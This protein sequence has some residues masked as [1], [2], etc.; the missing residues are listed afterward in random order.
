MSENVNTFG[1]VVVARMAMCD[2][3]GVSKETVDSSKRGIERL[4]DGRRPC[5][6]RH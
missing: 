2:S 6:K 3:G 5:K 1:L 4:S